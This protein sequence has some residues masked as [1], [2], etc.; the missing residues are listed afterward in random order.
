MNHEWYKHYI[1]TTRMAAEKKI[2]AK[3]LYQHPIHIIAQNRKIK[4]RT[5]V[6]CCM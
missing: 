4:V 2:A 6:V 1:N 3:P 5:Q